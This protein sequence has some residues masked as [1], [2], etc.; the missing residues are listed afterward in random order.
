MDVG[1]KIPPPLFAH[2]DR[3]SHQRAME[4]F[5][6]NSYRT[7]IS[8]SALADR[9]SSIMIKF[10]SILISILIVFFERIIEFNPAALVSAILFLITALISLAFS[11]LSAR[12]HITRLNKADENWADA[13]K[14]LFFFGNF[15][16]LSLEDYEKAVD[17]MMKDKPLIY[18]NMVRDIYHLG[19][20]LDTKFKYLKWSYNFFLLGLI[21]TVL[22]F[23]FSWM[24]QGS[25]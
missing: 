20:V 23:L 13:K 10:N 1:K 8:L 16:G 12:P 14:N 11:T 17:S 2:S 22:A 3:K 21:F 15:V 6:R 7:H 19:K 5:L 25:S 4:S 9:K 18:G 24:V